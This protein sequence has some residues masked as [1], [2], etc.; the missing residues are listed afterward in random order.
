MIEWITSEDDLHYKAELR[1]KFQIRT[2]GL[3]TILV[4][5]VIVGPSTT[6]SRF[7]EYTLAAG[8]ELELVTTGKY[9]YCTFELPPNGEVVSSESMVE[10]LEEGE[11]SMYDRLRQEVI[12]S[13]SAYADQRGYDSF[14]EADDFELD[15]DEDNMLPLTNYEFAAVQEEIPLE[16][17]RED[18]ENFS[19]ASPDQGEEQTSDSASDLP[20]NP[21]PPTDSDDA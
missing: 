1:T 12:S 2:M 16:Q 4:N 14:D 11:M 18:Q 7:M 19:R 20:D 9:S 3:F 6:N 17:W 13:M 8:D 21:E 15:D 10:I 5:G